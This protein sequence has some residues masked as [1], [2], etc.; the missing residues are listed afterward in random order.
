[1]ANTEKTEVRVKL[2]RIFDELVDV[3]KSAT[4]D[5]DREL[6]TKIMTGLMVAGIA[7]KND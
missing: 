6:A 2:E 5:T 7:S 3:C 1:M 4:D